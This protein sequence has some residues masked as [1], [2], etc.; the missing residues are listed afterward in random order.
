M[1]GGT[2]TYY[3]KDS[4]AVAVVLTGVPPRAHDPLMTLQPD[5][6]DHWRVKVRDA[7]TGHNNVNQRFYVVIDSSVVMAQVQGQ[8]Q[9]A[10]RVVVL[11][12]SVRSSVATYDFRK[13]AQELGLNFAV[14]DQ[15]I[16]VD[17]PEVA[18]LFRDRMPR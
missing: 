18:G 15:R 6:F 3:L 9:L 2:F 13:A 4:V 11:A 5:V 12:Q 7:V 16:D 14:V 17:N 1:T 10:V 8:D